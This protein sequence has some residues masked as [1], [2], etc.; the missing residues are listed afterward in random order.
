[1]TSSKDIS[2]WEEAPLNELLSVLE[3]GARPK[4]G[5]DQYKTGV[6][7]LGGEHLTAD[8]KFFLRNLKFI[9]EDFAAKLTRGRITRGD[10]LIVKDGATTGKCVLVS[11]SFPL[12]KAYINE[13]VFL[14]RFLSSLDSRF[15]AYFLR[16]EL[17]Q[18][19]ILDNF[20][21]AAQGGIP[22]SFAENTLVPVAPA[23]EQK[24]IADRLDTLLARVD[25]S[26]EH[27]DR[28]P[29]ILKRFRQA[30]L[31]AAV[32]GKLTEGWRE[33]IGESIKSWAS[34]IPLEGVKLPEN[35]KRLG[36][37]VFKLRKI[38]HSA[39]EL[40]RTWAVMTIA[41]LYNLNVLI[42]FADGNHGAMYPRKEDFT[43]EGELFLTASQIGENWEL[44]IQACPRL[45]SDKAQ[46]LVKG[47][48]QTYDVLLTHNATVGRVALLEYD[49]ENVLLGTSVTFYRFN[50]DYISPYFGRI[51]FSSPFFQNQL[52]MEMV[53]TTRN[54]VPITKQVSLNFICPPIKEQL[55][56]VQRVEALFAYADRLGSRYQ[57]AR[58]LVDNLTPALMD[59]AFSGELVPQDPNDE[60]AS[61]LLERIRAERDAKSKETGQHRKSARKKTGSKVEGVMRK[62][63]EISPTHL[64]DILKENGSML[65]ERLWAASELEIEDFYD[66]LKDEEL[67][68]LLKEIRNPIND[69]V[70]MLEAL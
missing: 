52:I 20:R 38:E 64:S 44:D 23:A 32:S 55:E 33:A 47:W 42:D 60:P 61:V 31:A 50:K 49:K 1:M 28:V 62:L 7:S 18:K 22:Q 27:L 8:G 40:P 4:G 65:P 15:F 30:V 35:Y 58:Q 37:I 9:P 10:V 39:G 24:R 57:T 56:I 25:T 66:Q 6:P 54:Q 11:E 41:D 2:Q 21:G 70:V 59:K 51:L 48:A 53:Q 67:K 19:R 17:G 46:L 3:T 45:R 5:V 16:S 29:G 43:Q 69:L 36:K 13:H 14:C 63:T 26:R 12:P 34:S 68:G